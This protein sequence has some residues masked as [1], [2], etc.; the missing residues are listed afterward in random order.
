V[1][2]PS[3]KQKLFQL[4]GRLLA[5]EVAFVNA[6]FERWRSMMD[7]PVLVLATEEKGVRIREMYE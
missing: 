6:Y 3:T 7:P 1:A 2:G 5:V 4:F